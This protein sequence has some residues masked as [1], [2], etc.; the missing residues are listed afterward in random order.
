MTIS[1][2]QA[3]EVEEWVRANILPIVRPLGPPAP[4]YAHCI[5]LDR[6]LGGCFHNYISEWAV[7]PIEPHCLD[8]IAHLSVTLRGMLVLD[9]FR[10]DTAI[11]QQL[12]SDCIQAHHQLRRIAI[13]SI[14]DVGGSSRAAQAMIDESDCVIEKAYS[15][16]NNGQFPTMSTVLG[17][18][19]YIR[20]PARAAHLAVDLFRLS[21]F[22]AF[23]NYYFFSLQLIDDFFD[24]QEDYYGQLNHTLFVWNLPKD[25]ADALINHRSLLVSYVA[26]YIGTNLSTLLDTMVH[27]APLSRRLVSETI[28]LMARW[29][30]GVASATEGSMNLRGDYE[31][32]VPPAALGDRYACASLAELCQGAPDRS[33]DEFRAEIIHER[34]SLASAEW[35]RGQRTSTVDYQV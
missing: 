29:T 24:M 32:Y 11:P 20:V 26:N 8:S 34:A 30:D 18:C 31:R 35:F 7:V 12:A 15:A 1:N 17:K 14:C 19:D 6:F 33:F 13:R 5:G 23:L 16:L 2:Q 28:K 21:Q 9:D 22:E 10:R 3:V 27:K 4:S 25:Q